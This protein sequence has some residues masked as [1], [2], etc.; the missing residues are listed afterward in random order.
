VKWAERWVARAQRRADLRAE[1]F[2]RHEE[3]VRAGTEPPGFLDG[4]ESRLDRPPFVKLYVNPEWAREGRPD[5]AWLR[6]VDAWLT[7]VKNGLVSGPDGVE[8]TIR[9]RHAGQDLPFHFPPGDRAWVKRAELAGRRE[10]YAV[11]VR[12]MAAGPVETIRSFPAETS[13]RWYAVELAREIRLA[14]LTA[15][16]P[17]SI[18]PARPPRTAGME[19]LVAEALVGVGGRVVRGI[20]WV[21]RRARTRWRRVRT[22]RR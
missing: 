15:L 9:V 20:L 8:V 16:R 10:D 17:S 1:R 14:G 18:V 13:A 7:W 4:I 19:E 3:A 21:P 22:G 12:R 2:R 11:C 6:L 5:D